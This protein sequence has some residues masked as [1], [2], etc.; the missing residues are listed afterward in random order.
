MA[1]L[2]HLRKFSQTKSSPV[3]N[4]VE[5][6]LP[7]DRNR[8]NAILL[9]HRTLPT[10]KGQ[11]LDAV[12]VIYSHLIHSDWDKLDESVSCLTP[13]RIKH[14]L[15]KSQKDHHLAFEFFKW[16]ELKNSQLIT[17][18]VNC[19]ALH[20][21]TK[22][23]KFIS[24][25]SI[26]KKT[27]SD[28]SID[29]DFPRKL[30][31]GL[32]YS[33][34]MC[35]SSSLV[36]DA[37]FKTHAHMKKFRN[38]S[39]CFCW[40]KEYG[41]RPTVVSCNAYLSSLNS[42]NRGDIA[43]AFYREMRRCRISPNVY[44]INMAI[45]AYCDLGKLDSAA[46]LFDETEAMGLSR[47][48]ASYNTLI[49]GYCSKGLAV[50]ALKLKS[51]MAKNGV[52]PDGF[53]Y[54]A[55]IAGLSKDGKL[56]E[57]SKL[58]GEMKS[59]GVPPTVVTYNALMRGY[60]ETGNSMRASELFEEMSKDGI[61]ADVL[62][63]NGV[64]SGLCKE[65]K[66]LKAARMAKRLDKEKLAPNASTFAALVCGHCVRG[67]PDRAL[68]V[69]RSMIR[70]GFHPDGAT[71]EAMLSAFV[72]CRDFVGAVEVMK[73]M[74]KRSILPKPDILSHIV[75]GLSLNESIKL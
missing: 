6:S 1:R 43:I 51:A 53:T 46:R 20:I 26:I 68:R 25:Q 50:E 60:G 52:D 39:D 22:Y 21:L 17:L 3:R 54:N 19:I 36:F 18:D 27:L 64:I 72:R 37:L 34:R 40:M 4:A 8:K 9:P 67:D 48:A 73:E 14:V 13:F 69:C 12:N 61:K 16:V 7:A 42:L 30:F 62:S 58:L 45:K 33:Y 59:R 55:L 70:N 49:S 66:T 15:L 38:A 44:T 57:A 65:G 23:R 74:A 32:V 11:D 47:N 28:A 24:A 41:F 63:Y 35:D 75:Q 5:S 71:F 29:L 10:A 31:D 56:S 2:S